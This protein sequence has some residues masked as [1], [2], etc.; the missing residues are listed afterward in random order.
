MLGKEGV[1]L[2][3]MCFSGV[4]VRRKSFLAAPSKTI[5]SENLNVKIVFCPKACRIQCHQKHTHKTHTR[6][7]NVS[8]QI[9]SFLVYSKGDNIVVDFFPLTVLSSIQLKKF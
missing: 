5:A 7:L 4:F 6:L 9:L 1:I 8:R 3:F 2:R